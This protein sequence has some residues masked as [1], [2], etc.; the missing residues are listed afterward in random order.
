MK[1]A[2]INDDKRFW[3]SVKP[4]FLNRVKTKDNLK[5]IEDART[6]TN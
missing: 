6:I 1:R 4:L 3:K 2:T 5:L